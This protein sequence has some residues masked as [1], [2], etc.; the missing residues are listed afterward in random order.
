MEW[1]P[2][3]IVSGCRRRFTSVGD[4][5]MVPLLAPGV[6]PPVGFSMQVHVF[7]R[8]TWYHPYITA[9]F[10]WKTFLLPFFFAFSGVQ[11]AL[12]HVQPCTEEEAVLT[13]ILYMPFHVVYYF[14]L[15]VLLLL[16]QPGLLNMEWYPSLFLKFF[17]QLIFHAGTCVLRRHLAPSLHLYLFCGKRFYFPCFLTFYGVQAALWQFQSCLRNN[18]LKVHRNKCRT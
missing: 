11:A 7:F 8:D 6:F 5:G 16:R 13:T 12:W 1:Y 9:C 4:H 3:I 15:C 14:S 10:L 17:H 2:S 18:R